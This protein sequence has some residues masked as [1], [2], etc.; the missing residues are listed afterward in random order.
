MTAE[1]GS[2]GSSSGAPQYLKTMLPHTVPFLYFYLCPCLQGLLVR[3]SEENGRLA[4]ENDKL[5]SGRN[6][7]RYV[8]PPG[9]Q[10]TP[11]GVVRRT[12]SN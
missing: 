8:P 3:F 5:R 6:M 7:L 9:H 10:L 12:T 2:R 1:P 11:P 4:K